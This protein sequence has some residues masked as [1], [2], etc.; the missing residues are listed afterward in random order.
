MTTLPT[1]PQGPTP[2]RAVLFD[3]D[4]TLFDKRSTLAQF[5]AAQFVHF[6]LGRHIADARSWSQ[7]FISWHMQLIPKTEVY[8]QLARA[9]ALAEPLQHALLA[10]LDANFHRSG[11]AYPGAVALVQKLKLAGLKTAVV[12]NGRDFFQRNK[13]QA[14][15]LIP[16]LD[17]IV[18]SGELG[19]K[20]PDPAIF[21]H[22]LQQLDVAPETAIFIGDNLHHD[23]IPAR[24]L[25]LYGI[26]KAAQPQA[27]ADF[28]SDDFHAIDA[29]LDQLL[30]LAH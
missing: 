6:G 14:L 22:C 26:L 30:Q 12:T 15:G 16:W 1:A 23:I 29:H 17:V 21:L 27:A 5:A 8:A 2:W 25:G 18:T 9:F 20:K 3:L 4:G 11:V 19:I 28:S 13:I 24:S 7:Q 10:D